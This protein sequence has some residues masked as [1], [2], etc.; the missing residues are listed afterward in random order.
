MRQWIAA[1]LVW[2][3]MNAAFA[4]NNAISETGYW[5]GEESLKYHMFD[6]R[7]AQALV[8]F[9]QSEKAQSVGDFGCG[10]GDYLAFFDKYNIPSKGYDGHPDT[11]K[12]TGGRA[13]VKDL[14]QP[15]EL[16]EK[17]DWVL[18]LEVAEH[19]PKQYEKAFIE[20]LHKHNRR[21]I[22]ISWAAKG[23][24]GFGHFNE[25]NNDY[26]KALMAKYGYIN[27]VV[28]EGA[29]RRKAGIWYLQNTVM[30]FRKNVELSELNK[31]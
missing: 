9:F 31:H 18:S 21:G 12:L 6:K 8:R 15:V 19:L 22:V 23:Q 24:G 7:L 2:A 17:F 29:L 4:Q 27:D 5:S 10:L 1:L 11:V 28:A 25:Q 20:N 16:K 13:E 3:L 30:V 26:V 14:S